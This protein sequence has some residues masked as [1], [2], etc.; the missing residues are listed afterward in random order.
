MDEETR[1]RLTLDMLK[2]VIER[3][4][5]IPLKTFGSSMRPV[6]HGGEWIAVRR[7]LEAEIQVGDIIIYQASRTFVAHR[8]IQRREQAGQVYFRIKGDAHLV[9]EGMV[10][11]G[12]IVARVVALKKGSRVINLEQ[13]GWRRVNRIIARY[14]AWLDNL[15]KRLP[16]CPD[17][18]SPGGRLLAA[19]IRVPP[20]LLMV[21]GELVTG[22]SR[23]KGQGYS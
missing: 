13:P 6:I 2:E 23:S 17:L 22:H 1:L 10:T 12:Q 5:E 14:S 19:L 4:L 15:Y 7:A 3:D 11:A 21:V 9:S 18:T 16:F 20:R 8:V